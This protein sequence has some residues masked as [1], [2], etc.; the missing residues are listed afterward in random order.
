MMD[1][2]HGSVA[3]KVLRGHTYDDWETIYDDNVVGFYKLVYR[4][5]GNRPDAEDL[6]SEI[7]TSALPHVE[8]P[9]SVGKV[10]AYLVAIART[11]IADHWRRHYRV[12]LSDF[13]IEAVDNPSIEAAIDDS[14][15]A[16][17]HRLLQRL[18]VNFRRVLELR[19]LRGYSVR[20]TADAMG[21]SVSNARVMQFRALQRAATMAEEAES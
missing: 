10:R 19:F 7:F 6:V 20:E 18:P 2:R 3:L 13:P 14:R 4:Q 11:V 12:P 16:R 15:V 1:E 21:I 5:V 9:A 17:V 8:L